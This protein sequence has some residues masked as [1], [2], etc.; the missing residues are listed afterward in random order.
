MKKE[1]VLIVEDEVFVA[2]DLQMSLEQMG[3]AIISM[4]PSGEQAIQKVKEERPDI[5][6][7]DIVLQGEMDGIETAQVM[8][9]KFDIPVIYVTAHGE[10]MIFERAKKTEPFGYIVKP[11]KKEELQKTIE[12]GLYKHKAEKERKKLIQELKSELADFQGA[13]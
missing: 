4:V 6:L 7:M 1:K 8:N 11:F 3:Y 9:S 5:V 10:E 13:V 2:R 12:M